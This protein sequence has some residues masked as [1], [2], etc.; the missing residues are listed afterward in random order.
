[1][2]A[3]L[4][5]I[6]FDLTFSGDKVSQMNSIT[7]SVANWTVYSDTIHF[8]PAMIPENERQA[9][10]DLY[11]STGVEN[12]Q[13]SDNWLGERGT[14][15]SWYGISCDA[16][17]RYVI[18]IEL[19]YNDLNG[20]IPHSI[21]NLQNLSDLGLSNNQ[22][23]SLPE[24]FGNLQNLSDLGLSDNQLSSL[25][26]SFGNLQHLSKLDVSINQLDSL[27]QNFENL[28]NRAYA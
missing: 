16:Y 21:V 14:E 8:I 3:G 9:L 26:E 23:S 4:S 11:N 25:P 17:E 2:P 20:E 18:K 27:P 24:S 1:M 13:K 10:I 5:E 22:L 12:W 15:C 6:T 19:S 7:P 28:I